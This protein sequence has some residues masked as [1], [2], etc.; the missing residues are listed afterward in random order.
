[1]ASFFWA[2]FVFLV[3]WLILFVVCYIVSDYGQNF[4]YDETTPMLALKVAG[5]TFLMAIL[6]AKFKPSFDT[7]FTAN[8]HWTLLQAF[9]WV[10]IFLFVFRFH[11]KHAVA[12]GL[13]LFLV[14]PGLATIAVDSLMSNTPEGRRPA[15]VPPAKPLR[16]PAY[17]SPIP[18]VPEKTGSQTA[19]AAIP[20]KGA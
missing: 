18:P 11:P 14:A 4:L 5:G 7:M 8:I 13:A 15:I 3:Y 9:I 20:G 12:L 1:M 16:K 6:L 17:P 2:I 19:P 10:R